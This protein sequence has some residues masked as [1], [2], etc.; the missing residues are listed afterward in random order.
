MPETVEG[1]SSC[2]FF[3]YFWLVKSHLNKPQDLWNNVLWTDE[4]KVEMF[5]HNA[6]QH[7]W[8]KSNAAYQHTH[9]VPTVKHSGERVGI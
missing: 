9:L 7:V 2:S 1:K 8:R 3:V 4:S 6:Q 5:G